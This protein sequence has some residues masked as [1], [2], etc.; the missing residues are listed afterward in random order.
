MSR[1]TCFFLTIAL[2]GVLN[3][4]FDNTIQAWKILAYQAWAIASFNVIYYYCWQE[5]G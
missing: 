2:W 4:F 1:T 5:K 3:I